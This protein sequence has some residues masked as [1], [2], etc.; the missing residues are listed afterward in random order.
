M[1]EL[2]VGGEGV[3]SVRVERVMTE[4]HFIQDLDAL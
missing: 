2:S 3:M 4:P 1:P